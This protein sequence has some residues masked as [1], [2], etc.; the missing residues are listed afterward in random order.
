MTTAIII[1]ITTRLSNQTA[2][3][4]ILIHC[5]TYTLKAH[6]MIVRLDLADC[7][8][9]ETSDKKTESKPMTDVPCVRCQQ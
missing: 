7:M 1:I 4:G 2:A 3:A 8:L 6:M 5:N 9:A